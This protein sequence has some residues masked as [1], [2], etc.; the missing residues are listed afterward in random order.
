VSVDRATGAMMPYI[1][2]MCLGLL[3]VILVPWVTLIVP[4]LLRLN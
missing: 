3:V 2:M 1:V 4:A